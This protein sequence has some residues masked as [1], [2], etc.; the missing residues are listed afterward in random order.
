MISK[1]ERKWWFV[2][3]V[4][5]LAV[6]LTTYLM[7]TAGIRYPYNF[8]QWVLYLLC[9]AGLQRGLSFATWLLVLFISPSN[10]ALERTK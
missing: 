1:L 2:T 3:T 4:S 9:L 8:S 5:V 6:I 10:E 7:E